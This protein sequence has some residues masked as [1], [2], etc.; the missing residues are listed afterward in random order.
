MSL[1]GL[2]VLAFV[3][4]VGCSHEQPFQ[5]IDET[6]DRPFHPGVPTR[7]T[8]NPG[9]DLR[10]AWLPDG[11]AIVYAW[12]QLDQPDRDRCLGFMNAA[13]GTRYRT[14]CNPSASAVDS[15]DLFDSPA[16]SPDDRLLYIR[17]ISPRNAPSTSSAGVYVGPLSD[18]LN[19]T[20]LVN[21][22][23]TPPGGSM[24]GHISDAHW[25]NDSRVMYLGEKVQYFP[26]IR[27]DPADTAITGL[28]IVDMELG[29]AVPS[30]SVVPGTS[31]ATSMTLT[32]GGDTLVYTLATDSRVFARALSTGQVTV[33]HDFGALGAV[34]DV[35]LR[36]DQLVAVVGTWPEGGQLWSVNLTSGNQA[37]L[38]LGPEVVQFRRPAF[39]PAGNPVRLVAEG[40]SL[41][42]VTDRFGMVETVV[43]PVGDLYLYE[44]P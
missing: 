13:G 33:L 31:G 17:G 1:H 44:A 21:L 23:S 41:T 2:R 29:G 11:S 18:P 42:T 14:V 24:Q 22:P 25:V 6:I 8:Y 4:L 37:P 16:P 43:S 30:L 34:S 38:P 12:Q 32:N 28:E 10:P 27:G 15:T 5:P 26:P 3:A 9:A 36:D 40:Y 35:A 39:A 19:A 7:L 20:K